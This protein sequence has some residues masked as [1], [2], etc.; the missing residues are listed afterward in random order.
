[1]NLTVRPHIFTFLSLQTLMSQSPGLVGAAAAAA[2]VTGNG[3]APGVK[4]VRRNFISIQWSPASKW[5]G[6]MPLFFFPSPLSSGKS[7][8]KTVYE[9]LSSSSTYVGMDPML[10]NI[11]R[12]L[13]ADIMGRPP[14]RSQT[15][16]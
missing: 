7:S 15:D 8:H 11:I 9:L 5:A 14:P 2:R 4:V 3:T 16:H 12:I 1:M 13:K 6:Q 10:S